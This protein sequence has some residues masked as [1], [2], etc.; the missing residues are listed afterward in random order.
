VT[1]A[2]LDHITCTAIAVVELVVRQMRYK[3]DMSWHIPVLH[4]HARDAA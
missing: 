1:V 4:K 2:A 3:V